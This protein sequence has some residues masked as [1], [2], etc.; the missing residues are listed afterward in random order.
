LDDPQIGGKLAKYLGLERTEEFRHID[1]PADMGS[2]MPTGPSLDR[3]QRRSR[4]WK[5]ASLRYLAVEDFDQS[6]PHN[7]MRALD[8]SITRERKSFE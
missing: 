8:T 4:R 7:A 1:R 3:V 6:P 5:K 2:V